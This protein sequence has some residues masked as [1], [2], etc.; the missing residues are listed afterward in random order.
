MSWLAD[1]AQID[2]D[3]ITAPAITQQGVL[4]ARSYRSDTVARGLGDIGIPTLIFSGSDDEVVP[5]ANSRDLARRIAHSRLII[6]SGAGY[7]SI[8]QYRVGLRHRTDVVYECLS[9]VGEPTA[10]SWRSGSRWCEVTGARG[11]RSF[12]RPRNGA[13]RTVGAGDHAA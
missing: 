10:R 3:D 9:V 7:A 5:V 8:F 12:G 13:D 1:V 2:P 4:V 6:F 11:R